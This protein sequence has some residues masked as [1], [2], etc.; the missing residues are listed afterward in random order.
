MKLFSLENFI[1]SLTSKNV[2]GDDIQL[3]L[4][5]WGYGYAG[6][7]IE[8]ISNNI[9][10]VEEEWFIDVEDNSGQKLVVIEFNDRGEAGSIGFHSLT[11]ATMFVN[12]FIERLKHIHGDID[13]TID[14]N[15]YIISNPEN[16]SIYI[17]E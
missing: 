17:K 14:N 16:I 1:S 2:S 6:S 15:T 5:D 12:S 11:A 13:I 10:E 8:E 7:T 3:L 9:A 4:N